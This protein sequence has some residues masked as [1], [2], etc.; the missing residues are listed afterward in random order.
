MSYIE[1]LCLWFI[2]K[3][4]SGQ[5]L[6]ELLVIR[7]PEVITPGDLSR[8]TFCQSGNRDIPVPSVAIRV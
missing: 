3:V 2:F 8:S 4:M 6:H 5:H 1:S 7:D